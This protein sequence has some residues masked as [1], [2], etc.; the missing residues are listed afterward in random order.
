MRIRRPNLPQDEKRETQNSYSYYVEYS[1]ALEMYARMPAEKTIKNICIDSSIAFFITLTLY[2]GLYFIFNTEVYYLGIATL[3]LL[4][5]FLLSI[6]YAMAVSAK[7]TLDNAIERN[8]ELKRRI[9]EM[10]GEEKENNY[11]E[12]RNEQG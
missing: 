6:A 11:K 9:A 3:V 4:C 7:R 8:E 1:L 10:N 2:W 5:P 12:I